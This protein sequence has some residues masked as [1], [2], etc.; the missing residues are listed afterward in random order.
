MSSRHN[1][2]VRFVQHPAADINTSMLSET[3][4][5]KAVLY[6]ESAEGFGDWRILLN[7]RAHQDL[8]K[9]RREDQSYF[10]IIFKKI[11]EL[12]HGYF[13]ADNQKRLNGG[14]NSGVP[15]YEAKVN[16][17][18]RLVAMLN[19]IIADLDISH[20]F[21]VSPNEQRVVE[22]TTS[23]YV[24]GRSGTG[25][26]T[27]M[28]FKMVGLENAWRMQADTDLPQI[29]QIFVTKSHV[30][31]GKVEEYFSDL[32][33]SLDIG[34]K[35][36]NELA[37]IAKQEHANLEDLDQ[38]EP[39]D[40]GEWQQHLPDRF[41]DLEDEHFP[42]FTT[43]D[44]LL[45]LLEADLFGVEASSGAP[46]RENM[47]TR[48]GPSRRRTGSLVSYDLFLQVYWNHFPE[49]LTKNLGERFSGWAL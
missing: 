24:I 38:I 47:T 42:L 7:G 48:V 29:R 27:T 9:A 25:K 39:E 21:H 10:K 31:A 12:S 36:L 49:N 26:T 11:R 30:L 46:L 45:R 35:S 16:G 20:V 2:P 13:S 1:D 32:L 15:I 23:C 34:T 4:P 33:V 19:G 8:R 40:D 43:T 22:H 5:V 14:S 41:S 6:F 44:R 17:D 37:I 28:M 18:V 3:Q